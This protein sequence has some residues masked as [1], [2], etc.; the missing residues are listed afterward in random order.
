MSGQRV[1]RRLVSVAAATLSITVGALALTGCSDDSGEAKTK[2]RDLTALQ[3]PMEET[4]ETGGANPYRPAKN[5]FDTAEL[6]GLE[7]AEARE[8]AA[9]HNCE[10][11][12]SREDDKSRPVPIEID[13]TRIYVYTAHGVVSQIEGVGGGL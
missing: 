4:G 13:P 7:L 3:C 1:H 5:A 8:K 11:I 12:V 10:I 6:L 9:R 2:G